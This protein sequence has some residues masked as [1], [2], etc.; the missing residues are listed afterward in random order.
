MTLIR[1]ITITDA[2]QIY[3]KQIISAMGNRRALITRNHLNC[4]ACNQDYYKTNLLDRFDKN[5]NVK[6]MIFICDCKRKLGLRL[7]VNNWFKIYDVTEINERKNKVAK[8]KRQQ[9]ASNN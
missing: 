4:P 6:Q 2:K 8:L 9:Y 7:L 3:L 1:H 5:G